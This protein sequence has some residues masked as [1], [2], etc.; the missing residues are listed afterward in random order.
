MLPVRQRALDCFGEQSKMDLLSPLLKRLIFGAAIAI[1]ITVAAAAEPK[2]VLLLHS[3]GPDI[4]PFSDVAQSFH[5]ELVKQSPESI[6][7][8]EASIYTPRL[9]NPQ[10]VEDDA[11]HEYLR[12]LYS[13]RKP[14][15]VVTIGA[16]ATYFAQRN[17]KQL[18][19]STPLLITGTAQRR[20]P[21]ESLAKNDAVVAWWIDIPS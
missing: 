11:L 16:P 17:R 6:D 10:D 19:P 7:F 21:L 13:N 4:S 1:G 3:F 9:Q 2:R 8:Y 14:N 12:N 5:K 15:L 18:F 20:I